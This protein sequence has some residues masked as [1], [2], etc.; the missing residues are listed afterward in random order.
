MKNILILLVLLLTNQAFAQEYFNTPTV[1]V[2]TDTYKCYYDGYSPTLVKNTKNVLKPEDMRG[3]S[4]LGVLPVDD[5][6]LVMLRG[7]FKQ[8]FSPTRAQKLLI[9]NANHNY[10]TGFYYISPQGKVLEVVF[11]LP[12]PCKITPIELNNLEKA[13]KNLTFQIKPG[14][15]TATFFNFGWTIDFDQLSR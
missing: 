7:V 2:G 11:D 5:N 15:T 6:W 3:N 9:S 14:C 4:C 10:I 8:V 12:T 1:T 13:L